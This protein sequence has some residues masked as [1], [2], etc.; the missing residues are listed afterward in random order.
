MKSGRQEKAF[1]NELNRSARLLLPESFW[2]KIP[3]FPVSRSRVRFSPV[4]PFDAVFVVDGTPVAVETKSHA[5]DLS[6]PLNRTA[7][8]QI[9]GLSAFGRAGG[10]AYVLLN[11]RYGRGKARVNFVVMIEIKELIAML[12]RKKSLSGDD[13]AKLPELEMIRT[14]EGPI[15]D[16]T[17]LADAAKSL[18]PG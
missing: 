9:E 4:K 1:L 18:N 10:A 16:L 11:V 8:H 15:W 6:W 12:K 5:S 3:D 7:P 14:E 13:L 2:Y 17:A